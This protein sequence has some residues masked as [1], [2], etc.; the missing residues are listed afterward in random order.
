MHK[1]FT[2]LTTVAAL[3]LAA[4]PALGLLQAAHAA[5]PTARISLVGLNLSNPAQ[6]AEFSAQVNAAAEH[7]CGDMAHTNPTGEF[8]MAGCKAAVRKQANSQLS[9]SQRHGLQ[10]ASRAAPLWV[11]SR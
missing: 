7:L 3:T 9:E 6:A 8:T 5:E 1:F 11:A 2:S 4:V 10:M